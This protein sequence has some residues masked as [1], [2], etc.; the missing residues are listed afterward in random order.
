MTVQREHQANTSPWQTQW[1]T[2]HTLHTRVSS[3]EQTKPDFTIVSDGWITGFLRGGHS[4]EYLLPPWMPS[5]PYGALCIKGLLAVL[6]FVVTE[7]AEHRTVWEWG[8]WICQKQW[9]SLQW[10]HGPLPWE[11]S[12]L[13]TC[14]GKLSVLGRWNLLC[15]R[16]LH[17]AAN[18][19]EVHKQGLA[20]FPVLINFQLSL[21]QYINQNI[22][23]NVALVWHYL[24]AVQ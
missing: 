11:C 7:T 24:H 1:F 22:H 15:G 19:T 4:Q 6:G 12:V 23:N 14:W 16:G 17:M 3:W 21:Q 13:C 10:L 20:L 18:S 2:L 8:T 5:S 9:H